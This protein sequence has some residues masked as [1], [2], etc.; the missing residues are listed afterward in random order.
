MSIVVRIEMSADA[1]KR[2]ADPEVQAKPKAALAAEGIPLLGIE[3]TPPVIEPCPK[4]RSRAIKF[5]NC[6]YSS[7]DM[8][9]AACECGHKIVVCGSDARSD[10]N[11][12]ADDQQSRNFHHYLLSKEGKQRTI[13]TSD[14]VRMASRFF[15]AE[16]LP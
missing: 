14:L 15:R 12:F 9:G 13:P 2:L 6:G 10:W 8:A 5:T 1:A 11:A 4:C 3:P 16:T 7:F